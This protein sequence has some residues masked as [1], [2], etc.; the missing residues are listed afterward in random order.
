MLGLML[1]ALV[2]TGVSYFCTTLPGIEPRLAG[3]VGVVFFGLGSLVAILPRL[4][5]RSA[6]ITVDGQGI[7]HHRW[8][9]GTIP[10]TDIE[11][12]WIGS[13]HSTRFLCVRLKAPQMYLHKLGAAQSAMVKVNQ[14]MGFGELTIGFQGLKPGLNEVWDYILANHTDKALR[15]P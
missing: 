4:A 5:N 15:Q 9:I 6:Q 10:W 7:L 13:V 8:K 3:W 1:L 14:N 12:V 11:Q 2:M